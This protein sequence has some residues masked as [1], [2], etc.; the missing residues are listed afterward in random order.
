METVEGILIKRIKNG[1]KKA[2]DEVYY[3]YYGKIFHF[4]VSYLKDEDFASDVVQE[5]FIK[6]WETRAS[7]KSH[8]RL[9]ALIFTITKNALISLFRKKSTEEKYLKYLGS[10]QIS[11]NEGTEE[12][13]NYEL[14]QKEYEK[15]IPQLPPKRQKVFLLSRKEGLSN[16]EIAAQLG[17]SEK[18]VENQLTQ[19]LAFF[20][21]QFGQSGFLSALFY[22]LF[23]A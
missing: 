14:L 22:F 11:N 4:C 12:M 2:L 18:T 17:I 16:K 10:C 3:L 8:T 13:V 1:D 5:T 19:A 23:I 9:E 6:L 15:L 21:K 20:K 7:L